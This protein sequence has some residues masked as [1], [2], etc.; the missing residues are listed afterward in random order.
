MQWHSNFSCWR[1]TGPA[2]RISKCRGLMQRKY[3]EAQPWFAPK[4][5]KFGFSLS[6]LAKTTSIFFKFGM[7]KGMSLSNDIK[8]MSKKEG[9]RPFESE[10]VIPY[11]PPTFF[12]V[13]I[14]CSNFVCRLPIRYNFGAWG[15]FS[16]PVTCVYFTDRPQITLF[17]QISPNI[18]YL[19]IGKWY[20][21]EIWTRVR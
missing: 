3:K 21:L 15:H 6:L 11:P 8:K 9:Q 12:L 14:F 19:R 16:P 17:A 1:T 5:E 13:N 2:L 10:E 4:G 18:L 7:N 20:R